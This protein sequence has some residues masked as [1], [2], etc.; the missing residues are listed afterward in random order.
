MLHAINALIISLHQCQTGLC[1][2][3]S[4]SDTCAARF[5]RCAPAVTPQPE[6]QGVL[7]PQTLGGQAA[8]AVTADV[9]NNRQPF[10]ARTI[11]PIAN[12]QASKPLVEHMVRA[13]VAQ[14]V[15]PAPF[16][17]PMQTDQNELDRAG[18]KFFRL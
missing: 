4:H 13:A 5:C 16:L 2:S 3:D 10:I 14:Q 15:T 6:V 17:R 8:K 18:R 7:A 12:A 9:L 1:I 11:G